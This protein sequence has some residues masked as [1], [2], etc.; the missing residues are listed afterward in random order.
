[1]IDWN[2]A[3]HGITVNLATNKVLNDGFNQV[4]TLV[5]IEGVQG[6][7]FADV[8]TGSALGNWFDARGG[9]DTMTGGGADDTF[10]FKNTSDSVV[11][12]NA[13]VITDF[14]DFGNDKIDLASVYGG[15]LV[16]KHN[17]IFNGVGQ[18]RINDIAGPDL[19]VEVNTGGSFAADMQI[20]L[21]NT[22]LLSMTSTDFVL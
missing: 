8:L 4:E 13:D 6:S 1:M 12:A 5:S 18:V 21:V 9:K 15:V 10:R 19:L 2:G 22:T 20:R 16:Y 11:G 3:V 17:A 14:D 7:G